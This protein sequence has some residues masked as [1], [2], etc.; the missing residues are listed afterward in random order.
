[1][2]LRSATKRDVKKSEAEI[3]RLSALDN[4]TRARKGGESRISQYQVAQFFY[5]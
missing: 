5:S 3:G 2:S 4:L 1:M